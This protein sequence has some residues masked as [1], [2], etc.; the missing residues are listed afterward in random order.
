MRLEKKNTQNRIKEEIKPIFK[1]F[2]K[3]ICDDL[4]IDFPYLTS[5]VH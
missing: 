3:A 1:E 4:T 2:Q 5:V